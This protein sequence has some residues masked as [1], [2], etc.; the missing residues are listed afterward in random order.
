[1]NITKLNPIG[2]NSQT[3]DGKTYKKSNIGKSAALAGKTVP[4]WTCT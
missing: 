1:M 4:S 3:P 2:Y